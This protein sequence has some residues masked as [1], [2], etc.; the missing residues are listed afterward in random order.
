[1][2]QWCR[3]SVSP[4]RNQ[5]NMHQALLWN[6]NREYKTPHSLKKY[7]KHVS[8]CEAET[9]RR[10][11][12]FYYSFENTKLITPDPSKA[13]QTSRKTQPVCVCTCV[14]VHVCVHTHGTHVA[15]CTC[16]MRS[17]R[18]PSPV[19]LQPQSSACQPTITAPRPPINLP[20]WKE[21]WAGLCVGGWGGAGSLAL[22]LPLSPSLLLMISGRFHIFHIKCP[23]PSGDMRGLIEHRNGAL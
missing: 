16:A 2:T 3:E 21:R 4:A 23:W 9:K 18:L 1:M 13:T 11:K 6:V 7:N 10:R 5:L 15:R 19:I 20:A 12:I 8:L 22:S 17:S 14:Y